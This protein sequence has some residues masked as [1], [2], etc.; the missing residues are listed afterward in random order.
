MTDCYGLVGNSQSTRLNGD[1][2]RKPA[3][4]RVILQQMRDGLDIGDF[5]AHD[6]LELT[7]CVFAL[8]QP[9]SEKTADAS[10]AVYTNS[11]H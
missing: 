5:V 8:V 11:G 6:Q 3:M 10:K 9:T 4:G 7:T 1:R 2:L